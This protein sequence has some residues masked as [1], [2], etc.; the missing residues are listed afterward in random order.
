MAHVFIA[1]R[2]TRCTI[3][4]LMLEEGDEAVYVEDEAV[5][6]ACAENE[7]YEVED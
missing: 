5:H 4:D 2:R 6:R 3:C 7:D 1:A